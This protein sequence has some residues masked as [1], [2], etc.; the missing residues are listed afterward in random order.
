MTISLLILL[1]STNDSNADGGKSHFSNEVC[2]VSIRPT[3]DRFPQYLDNFVEVIIENKTDKELT[4][5]DFSISL[6][7]YVLYYESNGR[8]HASYGNVNVDCASLPSVEPDGTDD[9]IL[10][11][12]WFRVGIGA[13][14]DEGV[15]PA[16]WKYGLPVGN[17]RLET[18]IYFYPEDHENFHV[19]LSCEFEVFEPN[20]GTDLEIFDD[21]RYCIVNY[22]E[23]DSIIKRTK[24]IMLHYPNHPYINTAFSLY[25]GALGGLEYSK[26]ITASEL[27]QLTK[28]WFYY[29]VKN[30]SVL[31]RSTVDK[32]ISSLTAGRFADSLKT[33]VNSELQQIYQQHKGSGNDIEWGLQLYFEELKKDHERA[34]H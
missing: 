18:T 8:E 30:S 6:R 33:D 2:E 13:L 3:M 28:Q 34:K 1:L 29:T 4:Y 17:F 19:P 16:G 27:Y 5:S 12:F 26:K 32:G 23:Y 11:L 9:L 25:Y 14:V 7:E 15:I 10:N 31:N 24:E 21:L 20:G 22:T